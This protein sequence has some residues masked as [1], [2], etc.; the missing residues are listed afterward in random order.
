[1]KMIYENPNMELSEL[2]AE[3]EIA[4]NVNPSMPDIGEGEGNSKVDWSQLGL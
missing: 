2:K 1:M 4:L 3:E